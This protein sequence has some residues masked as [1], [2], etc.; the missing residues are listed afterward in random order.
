MMRILV[1]YGTAMGGTAGV[2]KTLAE[3]LRTHGLQ[4]DVRHARGTVDVARYDAVIVGGALYLNRWHRD[5]RRFV[6]RNAALLRRRPVW[7]FSTG[8]LD[9]SA[10]SSDIAPVPGV[11]RLLGHIGARGHVTFGG[12]LSPDA[13]GFPAR[14]MAKEQAG[15]WRDPGHIAAWAAGVAGELAAQTP[16]SQIAPD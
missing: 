13:T 14:S 1:A 10:E 4:V 2:A 11:Q 9:G 12:R 8:P 15:D 6:Q 16:L 3:A 7:L 5:A